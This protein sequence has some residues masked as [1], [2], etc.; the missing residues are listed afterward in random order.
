M[1]SAELLPPVPVARVSETPATLNVVVAWM[2]T[3]PAVDVVI[4]IGHCPAA[5]V[6]PSMP[7]RQSSRLLAVPPQLLPSSGVVKAAPAVLLSSVKITQVPLGAGPKPVAPSPGAP[8]ASPSSCCTVA[9][10]VCAVPTS[11]VA[12]SGLTAIFASTTCNGSHALSLGSFLLAIAV[13]TPALASEAR[14]C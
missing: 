5:G 2:S 10:I 4:V 11:F 14:N 7:V 8:A 13:K 6:V 9:V 12:V 1:A 3:E